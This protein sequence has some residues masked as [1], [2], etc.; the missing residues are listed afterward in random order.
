MIASRLGY[1]AVRLLKDDVA[2]KAVGI[3]GGEVRSFDLREAL[4]LKD[5]KIA[6]LNF[7]TDV[8]SS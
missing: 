8:L 7:L 4:D 5:S 6:D 2:G 1:E 3:V